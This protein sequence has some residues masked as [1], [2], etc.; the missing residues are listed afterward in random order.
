MV[1]TVNEIFTDVIK[2][3]LFG[4]EIIIIQVST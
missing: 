3:Q 2:F 4:G 1:P